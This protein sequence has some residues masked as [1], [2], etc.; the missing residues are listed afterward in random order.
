MTSNAEV[1]L[2]GLVEEKHLSDAPNMKVQDY[3]ELFVAE[4]LLAEARAP[5]E[6]IVAGLVG[7]GG[8]GGIDAIWIYVDGRP[9]LADEEIPEAFIKGTQI[10]LIVMQAKYQAGGF[11][12]EAL[13]K[14]ENTCNELLRLDFDLS[15]AAAAYSG[16]VLR[17]FGMF[18][19]VYK[20]AA[21]AFPRLT[22]RVVYASCGTSTAI[23]TPAVDFRIKL[24][25]ENLQKK[26]HD[27]GVD[28]ELLG[29][30]ELFEMAKRGSVETLRLTVAETAIST[31]RGGYVALVNLDDYY[32]FLVSE[33]GEL[34]KWLFDYNVRDY[35]GPTVQVNQAIRNTLDCHDA[36]E[37]FWWLNN[38]VSVLTDEVSSVGKT[39]VVSAPRIVNGLQTSMEV[40]NHYHD[41]AD[42]AGDSRKILVRIIK[43]TDEMSRDNIIK[44]TNSQTLI[45]GIALKSSEPI[46]A[47]IEEFLR[48]HDYWYERRQN[49]Y[50]R[51][52][53]SL[54]RILTIPS[55]AEAVLATVYSRPHLGAAR[56]GNFL[57]D[58]SI[59][60]KAY[61]P[62]YPLRMYLVAVELVR[63][64]D[65]YIE[66][67]SR[68]ERSEY[69]R[70][71]Y[72]AS[73][74]LAAT[75]SRRWCP[76]PQLI[77]DLDLD[78]VKASSVERLFLPLRMELDAAP[79]DA[80]LEQVRDE[81]LL[82]IKRNLATVGAI[83]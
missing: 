37:D 27:C 64:V 83:A 32:A 8:D 11:S 70:L 56:G 80:T 31:D 71:T 13:R 40:Y 74:A 53:K 14:I 58:E 23:P 63:H 52:G 5:Y 43:A 46:H 45:P 68:G 51:E 34:R 26:F 6:E 9:I 3:F 16:P 55:L 72:V 29:A 69:S 7:G 2:R 41:T 19:T 61:N 47:D 77:A 78:K 82:S 44:A 75:Q 4:L 12:E 18:H 30:R 39:L 25:R 50:K 15:K 20:A 76:G 38:G 60:S 17:A 33:E 35:E 67:L 24:L 22:V 42:H 66:T 10:E 48:Q 36:S 81:V 49:K 1:I 65:D 73:S 54:K 62:K 57:R 59:Y 79:R 28:V 21:A